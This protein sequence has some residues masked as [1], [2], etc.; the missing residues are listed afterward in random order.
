MMKTEQKQNQ[1]SQI[2]AMVDQVH[3]LQNLGI[4]PGIKESIVCL[5]AMAFNTNASC[6]GHLDHGLGGPWADIGKEMPK[7]TFDKANI[8]R[9]IFLRIAKVLKKTS[10]VSDKLLQGLEIHLIVPYTREMRRQKKLF[11]RENL[12]QQMQLV[13]LLEEFYKNREVS[14]D[15][16][17]IIEIAA[18]RL[19]S[20]GAR[21]R[22]LRS[23]EEKEKKLKE[24]KEEMSAFTNFLK[25]KYFEK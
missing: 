12:Q 2:R 25:K 14:T 24:Y 8:K 17:L 22:E 15:V 6:E 10:L 1:L 13:G 7:I 3:D 20:Q 4:E 5:W 11:Q 21:F 9:K 23:S 19:I 18:G 16:R